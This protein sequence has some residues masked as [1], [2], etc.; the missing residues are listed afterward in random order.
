M[1]K[2]PVT[3]VVVW[4]GTRRG[5]NEQVVTA[6]QGQLSHCRCPQCHDQQDLSDLSYIGLMLPDAGAKFHWMQI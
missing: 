1:R 2:L 4:D 6:H 5:T 3:N